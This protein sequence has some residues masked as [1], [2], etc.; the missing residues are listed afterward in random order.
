MSLKKEMWPEDLNLSKFPHKIGDWE[1]TEELPVIDELL[2]AEARE[3]RVIGFKSFNRKYT[4]KEGDSVWLYIGY[5]N[6]EKGA[7]SHNPARC[8][9]SQGWTIMDENIENIEMPGDINVN[10][11]F[12]QLGP[13]QQ[14]VLYWFQI[15][16][17]VYT[18]KFKHRIKIL[19]NALLNGRLDAV[20]ISLTC[21]TE[22]NNIKNIV[23]FEKDFAKEVIPV[24][25]K[26]LPK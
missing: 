23:E 12:A 13:V 18:D 22:K 15:D 19:K 8:Y 21:D 25:S 9:L 1:V 26:Y 3:G 6:Y 5:F 4:N 24:I 2:P 7:Y 16:N 14:I 11:M 17:K 10:R 20:I